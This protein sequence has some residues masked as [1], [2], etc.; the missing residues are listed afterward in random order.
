MRSPSPFLEGPS[1]S[2]T[3]REHAARDRL[4]ADLISLPRALSDAVHDWLPYPSELYDA[5]IAAEIEAP[6][7]G[8][9]ILLDAYR[10]ERAA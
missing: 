5:A 10:K 6:N 4:D 8:V 7:A 1:S 2:E 9:V 3:Q